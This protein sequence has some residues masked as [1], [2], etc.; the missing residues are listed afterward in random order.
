MTKRHTGHVLSV[1]LE[2]LTKK[3]L[4]QADSE[5]LRNVALEVWYSKT[6]LSTELSAFARR[7]RSDLE[8][9][10]AGYLLERLTRFTCLSENRLSE[11]VEGLKH[12]RPFATPSGATRRRSDALAARWGLDEGLGEKVQELL[13]YQ[14]RH[15]AADQYQA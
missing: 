13:P 9:R 8:F 6:D 14:T 3:P 12:F 2:K 7:Q 4:N 10:R 1:A 11:T 5:A 15:Y